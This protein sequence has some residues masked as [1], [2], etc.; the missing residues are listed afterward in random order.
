MLLITSGLLVFSLVRLPRQPEPGQTEV[1]KSN[2]VLELVWTLIPLALLVLLL[3]LTYQTMTIT[4]HSS[5]PQ[6][7]APTTGK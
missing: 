5:S 1:G 6:T 4:N 7:T 2:R 3:V